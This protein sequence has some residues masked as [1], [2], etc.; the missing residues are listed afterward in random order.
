MSALKSARGGVETKGQRKK[1]LASGEAD[2]L[3]SASVTP[4]V[5]KKKRAKKIK[6]VEAEVEPEAEEETEISGNLEEGE[7]KSDKPDKENGSRSGESKSDESGLSESSSADSGHDSEGRSVIE[8]D[9]NKMF[10][11]QE[12]SEFDAPSTD[13]KRGCL[14]MT[15]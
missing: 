4:E 14:K 9:G 10:R 11:S 6:S 2:R 3:A 12:N 13:A 7:E 5:D 8:K 15:S 1:R